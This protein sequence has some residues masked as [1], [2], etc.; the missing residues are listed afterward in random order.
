MQH[1]LGL[2][3]RVTGPF[4]ATLALTRSTS[5]AAF[6]AAAMIRKLLNG[7]RPTEQ[8]RPDTFV[9]PVHNCAAP[10][11]PESAS[12][13]IRRH[14]NRFTL[15]LPPMLKQNPMKYSGLESV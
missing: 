11:K 5:G 1:S 8:L 2:K 15:F 3:V 14:E 4:L 6:L 13:A 9:G 10:A 12:P 7:S